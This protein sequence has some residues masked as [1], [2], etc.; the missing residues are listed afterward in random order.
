MT[1]ELVL[2]PTCQQFKLLCSILPPAEATQL[3]AQGVTSIQRV[4]LS[5]GVR[6][7]PLSL[8]PSAASAESQKGG[9][10]AGSLL[11]PP[12]WMRLLP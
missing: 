9:W 3:W 11:S 5:F 10:P 4:V 8:F 7:S 2:S 12:T 6:A 1:E